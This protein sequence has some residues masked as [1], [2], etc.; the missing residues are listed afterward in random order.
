MFCL[1]YPFSCTPLSSELYECERHA[2]F[3]GYVLPPV[4]SAFLT[5]KNKFS[6]M[7]GKVEIRAKLPVGSY[8]YPREFE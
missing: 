7:F 3:G 1:F 6:F 2:L 5:T 8:I 4:S